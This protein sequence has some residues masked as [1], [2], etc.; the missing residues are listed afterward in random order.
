MRRQ[1]KQYFILA[2]ILSGILLLSA[3]LLRAADQQVLSLDEVIATALK[4]NPQ[5]KAAQQK[6]KANQSRIKSAYGL[7]DPWV[8]L[9]YQNVPKGTTRFQDADMKMYT[10]SQEIP[11]PGKLSLRAKVSHSQAGLIEA[12]YKAKERDI[13]A[14]VK[15]AYYELYLNYKL[16]AINRENAELAKQIVKVAESKYTVGK[17][18]LAEVLKMQ[19]EAAKLNNQLITL[20]NKRQIAQARI[21]TLLNRDV[22]TEIGIPEYQEEKP[23]QYSLEELYTLTKINRPELLGATSAIKQSSLNLS[24]TR[25][26]YFPDFMLTYKQ[27]FDTGDMANGWDGMFNVTVPLWFWQKQNNMVNEMQAE[28]EMVLAD[29]KAMENMALLEVKQMYL[30]LDAAQRQIDL[31]KNSILPQAEQVLKVSQ[32]GYAADKV[33][34]LDLLDSQ[35]MYLE[36]QQDYYMSLMDYQMAKA[37][38]EQIVGVDIP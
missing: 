25:R 28:K 1:F 26:E 20:E 31:T 24:L 16:I 13:I 33:E 7:P 30:K 10:I 14:Q 22:S 34:F 4:D 8:G 32:T 3:N 35:R 9:E 17:A 5:L 12:E 38:L 19:V 2:G 11:W 23:F 29:Y 27:R 6:L 36:A 37:E 21:N 15:Q 18:S